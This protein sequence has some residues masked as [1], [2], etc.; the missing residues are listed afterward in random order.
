VLYSFKAD[1]YGDGAYPEAGLT[2]VGGKL[3][4]TTGGGGSGAGTVFEIALTGKERVL[5]RFASY[6]G[7][8]RSPDSALVARG[9]TLYGTTLSGGTNNFGT[10]F[11]VTR[12]GKERVLHRFHGVPDGLT[13]FGGL[14][15]VGGTLYGTTW[16][17]GMKSRES[18]AGVGTIFSIAPSG[19]ERVVYA[20]AGPPDG[21]LVHAGLIEVNGALYGAAS[22]GGAYPEKDCPA[23][24]ADGCGAIFKLTL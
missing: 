21:A 4:G 11:S 14:V 10:V 23:G 12:D 17:G 1:S 7:D 20:F 22:S 16:Q 13:P 18:D 9:G 6:G 19:K 3:Y 5:Y 15:D 8:G 24:Y 2:E